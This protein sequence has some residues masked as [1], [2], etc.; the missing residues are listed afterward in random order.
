L[1]AKNFAKTFQLSKETRVMLEKM[2]A[3]NMKEIIKGE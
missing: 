2:L 3:K 1:V